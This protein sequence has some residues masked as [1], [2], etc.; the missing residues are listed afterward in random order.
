MF[1]H[2]NLSFFQNGI[3]Y[4]ETVIEKTN[5]QRKELAKKYGIEVLDINRMQVMFPSLSLS[6]SLLDFFVTLY[7][8]DFS[9]STCSVETTLD[10]FFRESLGEQDFENAQLF[11][12]DHKVI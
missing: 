1:P 7:V 9:M 11:S 4:A 12:L 5:M 2:L 10:A 8:L 6:L 3:Q